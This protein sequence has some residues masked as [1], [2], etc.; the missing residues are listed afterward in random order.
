MVCRL[1][2]A[3]HAAG[4]CAAFFLSAA[5]SAQTVYPIDRASI[6]VGTRFDFKV[7]FPGIVARDAMQITV[8]G[9]P[10]DKTFGEPATYIENEDGKNGS[11]LVVRS[12]SLATPG[13]YTVVAA[14][15]K[16]NSRTVAWDVFDT[17]ARKAKNVILFVGDG[18]S[19]GHVTAA[20]ILSKQI[21]EGK[22]RGRLT[23]DNFPSM[24]LIGTSGTDSVVTDSANSAHAY[25][26]GHKSA[27]NALGVYASRA[28]DNLAHPRVETLT[29]I[30]KRRTKM[31]V[32]VV[33][34][35]EIEDATPASMVAHTRRRSD[36]DVIVAQFLAAGPDV[37][38]GGGASNF[39]PRGKP[40]SRRGDETD[41]IAKFQEAG[42]KVA[43]TDSE[44]KAAAADGSTTKLLGLYHPRNMDGVL[45][46]RFLKGGT[47][48][49]FPNQPDL[50]DQV[51]AAIQVLSRN[52]D[53]FMMMVESG[54]IDKFAHPLDWERSVYDTIM[55]DNAVKVAVDFAAGRNDT[56][57]IVLPDHTH[58]IS[59]IGTVDDDKPG[60]DMR[61]KIGVYDQAKY[62]NY[63]APDADGYP[64][65][66]D[67]SRRLAVFFNNFPDYY[68]TFRPK[69]G[70]PNVPAV[71]GPDRR[72]VANEA[73]KNEP[74]AMFRAGL[75]PRSSDTGV[76]TADDG[77]A[78]ATGP[79]SEMVHG[80]MDNTEIF[81]VIA[82]ALGLGH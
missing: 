60:D 58:G 59:I 55:L 76:H 54:L 37:M 49:Q 45:D 15:G 40:G 29:E 27:V 12:A 13:H 57:I 32:G 4:L 6:L 14:D 56:L 18:L 9:Q 73:Y 79:G 7:E 41:Y 72:Y 47:V 67:V 53:G 11:S 52:E 74:G 30:L 35:T 8:N 39:I 21:S 62:P 66:V 3:G 16:G 42:Y 71:Q 64:T 82:T 43:T 34:N 31:G 70:G 28:A 26:T 44:M 17:P 69:M 81:K 19:V 5:A 68:E 23:I 46:R 25:T 51:A 20:R 10:L 48:K 2:L 65:K 63:P 75:L 61:E 33:T 1:R 22:Y 78:R 50:T 36:Y 77:V 24:A 38:M 80:F